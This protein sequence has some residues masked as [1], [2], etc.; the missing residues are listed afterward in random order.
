M[1]LFSKPIRIL[2][3]RLI[4]QG[5]RTTFLWLFNHGYRVLT[6]SPYRPSSELT[7]Q[8]LFGGQYYAWGKKRMERWG[9][10]AVVNMREEFDDLK[11]GIAPERYL[12]LPTPDDGAPTLSQLEQGV[13]F[14]R[15]VIDAGGKVYIHCMAGVGRAAIITAAYLVSQGAEPEEAWDRVRSVRPFIKPS[16]AQVLQLKRFA[17][18]KKGE[19]LGEL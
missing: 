3:T 2:K 10:T 17:E 18:M 6:G 1:N 16:E 5:P 15:E 9:I 13:K 4:D 12:H 14:I 19:R 11:A 7:P 8:L